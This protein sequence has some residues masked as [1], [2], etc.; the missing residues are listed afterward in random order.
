VR[1]VSRAPTDWLVCET[2]F[3]GIDAGLF[4]GDMTIHARSGVLLALASQ[5]G[6][7]RLL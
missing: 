3:A 2:R 7:V 1:I 6:V 4:H 5:S